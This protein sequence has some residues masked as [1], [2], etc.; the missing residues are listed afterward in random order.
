MQT[1]LAAY[2]DTEKKEAIFLS[3]NIE[4]ISYEGLGMYAEI[5]NINLDFVEIYNSKRNDEVIN[6]IK[7]CL[8]LLQQS[9]YEF[10]LTTA[11][12]TLIRACEII[13]N[14]QEYIKLKDVRKFIQFFLLLD[15]YDVENEKGKFKTSYMQDCDNLIEI[16]QSLRTATIHTSKN[17]DEFY[18]ES[19]D[20]NHFLNSLYFKIIT[21]CRTIFE[22]K[23][24]NYSDLHEYKKNIMLSVGL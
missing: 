23:I 5:N 6:T 11:F 10:D 14:P 12:N 15:R 24:T 13:A 21:V 4:Y 7:K 1:Q 19:R 8:Y 9:L 20:V 17:L 16:F 22:T 18:N 3:G 2:V